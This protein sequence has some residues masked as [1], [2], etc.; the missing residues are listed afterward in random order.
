MGYTYQGAGNEETASYATN[1]LLAANDEITLHV[2]AQNSSYNGEY[3]AGLTEF[4][5]HLVS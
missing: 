4:G 3:Y 2:Q 5:G 1:M